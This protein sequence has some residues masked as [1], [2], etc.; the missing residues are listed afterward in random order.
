MVNEQKQTGLKTRITNF[1]KWKKAAELWNETCR[2]SAWKQVWEDAGKSH[3]HLSLFPSRASEQHC[4][5][6]SPQKNSRISHEQGLVMGG[7]CQIMVSLGDRYCDQSWIKA[8]SK[9][10][11]TQPTHLLTN[12][13]SLINKLHAFILKASVLA[14]GLTAAG[15]TQPSSARTLRHPHA[16]F[17]FPR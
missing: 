7:Q 15:L 13:T 8:Q 10:A 5:N 9:A 14:S 2:T 11:C 4:S 6:Y 17:G 12:D 3:T 1:Y 16:D